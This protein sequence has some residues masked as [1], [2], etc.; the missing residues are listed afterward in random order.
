M[1]MMCS[2][3]M[4]STVLGTVVI[5]LHIFLQ[6]AGMVM[7]MLLSFFLLKLLLLQLLLLNFSFVLL[8]HFYFIDTTV[9]LFD[10]H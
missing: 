9:R 4:V 2:L 1:L 5:V 6:L 10:H 7:M 3:M 8:R